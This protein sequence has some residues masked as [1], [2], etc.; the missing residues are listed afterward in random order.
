MQLELTSIF[1]TDASIMFKWGAPPHQ[2][3]AQF[4]INDNN[5]F[6]VSNIE[7]LATRRQSEAGEQLNMEQQCF[8]W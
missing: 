3:G 4:L 1:C 2:N 5:Y 8:T 7:C 6:R